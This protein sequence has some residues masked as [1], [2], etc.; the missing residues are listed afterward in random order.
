MYVCNRET[1]SNAELFW[2]KIYREQCLDSRKSFRRSQTCILSWEWTYIKS[3]RDLIYCMHVVSWYSYQ[4]N[5][6]G[7]CSWRWRSRITSP[8][9][10]W[11]DRIPMDQRR[12]CSAV[13]NLLCRHK[14]RFLGLSPQVACMHRPFVVGRGSAR[15]RMV[16]KNC[17][18]TSSLVGARTFLK[19]KYH[20]SKF[21]YHKSQ[22]SKWVGWTR[23]CV[24]TFVSFSLKQIAMSF[25]FRLWKYFQSKRCF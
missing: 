21:L 16:S 25:D 6:G 8:T 10:W 3:R 14:R 13:C 17:R 23:M 4:V 15:R 9:E 1:Y 11:C 18:S 7:T 22:G 24:D 12:R 5:C 19:H 20:E 2:I